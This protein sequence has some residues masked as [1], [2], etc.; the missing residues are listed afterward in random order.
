MPLPMV[1]PVPGGN[2][3]HRDPTD[4]ASK[5]VSQAVLPKG[6]QATAVN[7]LL[8]VGGSP[9]AA[10]QIAL[11]KQ[12]QIGILHGKMATNFCKANARLRP[13]KAAGVNF[14]V[15]GDS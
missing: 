8:P 1:L 9:A 11:Y 15:C 6:A 13:C 4:Q 5:A 14:E 2:F 10:A 3:P 12:A 7:Q